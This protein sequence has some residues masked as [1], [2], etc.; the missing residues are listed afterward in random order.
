MVARRGNIHTFSTVFYLKVLKGG[1]ES[2]KRWTK[3]LDIFELDLLLVP[4]FLGNHWCLA[5]V[6]LIGRAIVYYDSY[7]QSNDACL[8]ALVLYLQDEHLQK[9]GVRIFILIDAKPRYY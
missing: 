2:V 6:D 8:D 4:V 5:V 9:K 7:G 1:H 3:N